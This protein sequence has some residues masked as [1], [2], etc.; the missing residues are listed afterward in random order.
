MR[1]RMAL[2]ALSLT[3][4]TLAGC[5]SGDPGPAIQPAD[6]GTAWSMTLPVTLNVVLVGWDGRLDPAQFEAMLPGS[7][8]VFNLV[9]LDTTRSLN[10][11]P[12]QYDV[13]W[14]V[15][16]APDA[17]ADAFFAAAEAASFDGP[18]PT[19]LVN[20]DRT[21]G[22]GRFQHSPTDGV[23]QD[24]V[25]GTPLGPAVEAS[26]QTMTYID[27]PTLE[28]WLHE[29][30]GAFGLQ[31]PEPQ[32]TLFLVDSYT[33]GGLPKDSYHYY[34][35]DD[36]TI[37]SQLDQ[38]RPVVPLTQ[39]ET[40]PKQQG[41]G[42]F[43]TPKD[44]TSN[45]GWGGAHAFS[46]VDAGSAPSWLD[47][48]PWVP[49][50][51]DDNVDH[52]VWDLADDQ[53]KLLRNLARHAGDWALLKVVRTP[54]YDFEYRSKWVFPVHVYIESSSISADLPGEIGDDVRTWFKPERIEAAFQNLAPWVET[55]V[56]LQIHMLPQD[57]PGMAQA[58]RLAEL[59]GDPQTANSG[60]IEDYVA[61][62]WDK[63][64]PAEDAATRVI[65]QFLFFFDGTFNFWGLNQ[66][67]G[68]AGGDAWGRPWAVFSHIFDICAKPEQVPCTK[69]TKWEGEGSLD[70]LV[71]HEAG[72]EVG[73]THARDTGMLMPDGSAPY[74]ANWLWDS[75]WSTMTYRH[76]CPCFDQYD[77]DTTARGHTAWALDLVARRL[78]E[79][80]EG[81][82]AD[83]ARAATGDA[84]G[85]LVAGDW[86]AAATIA[87]RAWDQL[88]REAGPLA[89]GAPPTRAESFGSRVLVPASPAHPVAL[90]GVLGNLLPAPPGEAAPRELR[91]FEVEFEVRDDARYV[92]LAL[93]DN[94][95]EA[96]GLR[97]AWATLEDP[98]GE[99]AGGVFAEV[100]DDAYITGLAGPGTYKAILATNGGAASEYDLVVDVHYLA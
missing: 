72:H 47:Y 62:N 73:L 24:E 40:T 43:H 74:Y 27:A 65:P 68:Y 16:E 58:I 9:E 36:G 28:E 59:Y 86:Q 63:Y 67:G 32:Y 81:A 66:G 49:A 76:Q 100:F 91:F 22:Q 90:P 96:G 50:F 69:A 25:S 93:R 23:V 79:G 38:E 13:S 60:V 15:H 2:L 88:V 61:R 1:W 12:I 21:S 34:Y 78:A 51:E 37:D 57:D 92:Y 84:E 52:P 41:P 5:L 11:E 94:R 6:T 10:L 17:F 85:K 33:G 30:L 64:V 75:S 77:R 97:Q 83:A 35:F 3:A 99:Y 70:L 48:E 4:A 26:G 20:Y 95:P 54:I 80:V 53:P 42:E 89:A 82:A 44:P 18:A 29:N 14:N 46:W 39:L 19:F 56:D 87:T 55:T 7:R 31:F 45:R 71:I 98:Q 8:P